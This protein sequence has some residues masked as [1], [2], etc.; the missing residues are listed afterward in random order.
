[1]VLGEEI[2]K[3]A[4]L[5]D[6]FVERVDRRRE[7]RILSASRWT[8]YMLLPPTPELF[9]LV[10]AMAGN[11]RLCDEFTMNFNFPEKQWARLASP[12]RIKA[13]MDEYAPAPAAVN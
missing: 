13:W 6:L 4:A 5:D 9:G 3:D 1:V 7:D 12:A 2:V 11:Q 10:V 8:N